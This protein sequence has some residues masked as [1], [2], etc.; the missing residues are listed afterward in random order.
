MTHPGKLEMGMRVD[1]A[2]ENSNVAEVD[3]FDI[4]ARTAAG[5]IL[6]GA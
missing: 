4:A 5:V 3:D 6:S 1:E 2:G